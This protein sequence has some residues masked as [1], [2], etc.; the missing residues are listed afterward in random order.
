MRLRNHVRAAALAWR[1]SGHRARQT[2]AA[3][4]GGSS[5]DAGSG[6]AAAAPV[7]A[8]V[9]AGGELVAGPQVPAQAAAGRNSSKTGGNAAD[10]Q[11]DLAGAL[12]ALHCF[13]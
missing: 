11:R 10:E 2:A 8:P 12:S 4:E 9:G 5:E 3:A 13:G 1:N 6:A 7:S